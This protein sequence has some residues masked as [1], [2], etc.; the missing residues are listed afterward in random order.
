ML[1][2]HPFGLPFFGGAPEVGVAVKT[3]TGIGIDQTILVGNGAV[4]TPQPQTNSGGGLQPRRKKLN[5]IPPRL[6]EQGIV[7]RGINARITLGNATLLQNAP[8]QFIFCT[9]IQSR[10]QS[11]TGSLEHG[12]P[13]PDQWM[14][15]L[16]LIE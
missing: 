16:E 3:I 9:G 11:G 5:W 15:I 2:G 4:S 8:R 14:I 7:G 6:I 12:E 10:I 1:G 13:M